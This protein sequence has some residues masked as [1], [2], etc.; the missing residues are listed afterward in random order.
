MNFKVPSSP[1][2]SDS[3]SCVGQ[4]TAA[5]EAAIPAGSMPAT[6]YT[7]IGCPQGCGRGEVWVDSAPCN[8]RAEVLCHAFGTMLTWLQY[9]VPC[10][11]WRTVLQHV[12]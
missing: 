12:V 7:Q 3:S 2:H 5:R 4:P 8:P 10:G 9:L 1:S 11:M 6:G